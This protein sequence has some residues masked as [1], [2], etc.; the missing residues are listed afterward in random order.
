MLY[1]RKVY[2]IC[3]GNAL[4]RYLYHILVI[5]FLNSILGSTFMLFLSVV[6]GSAACEVFES[7]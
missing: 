6:L 4:V 7:N 2:W 5:L 1:N 3:Y